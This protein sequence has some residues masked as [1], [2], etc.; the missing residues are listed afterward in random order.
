MPA[1]WSRDE[2]I[3]G[4]TYHSPSLPVR[5]AQR[6]VCICHLKETNSTFVERGIPLLPLPVLSRERSTAFPC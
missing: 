2:L 1:V 3:S 6:N 5:W 4:K